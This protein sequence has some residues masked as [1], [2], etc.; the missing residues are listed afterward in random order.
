MLLQRHTPALRPMTTAHL[1]QTM[2]LLGLTA[3]ELRE[4]IEAELSTNPALELVEERRCPS[5]RRVLPGSSSCPL[6][7]QPRDLLSD[8]PIVFV[9]PRQDFY[10]YSKPAAEETVDD[11]YS[12]APVEQSLAFYV[13][14]QIAP[15][16]GPN[17]RP[18]AAHILTSLDED[19]LLTVPL[20]EIARYQHVM[21]SSVEKVLK[22]IQR[23]D[24]IGVGS[25][26]PREA[27]LVQLEVLA[28][29]RPVP[30]L[31]ALAIQKGMDL[32][33]HRRYQELGRLLGI[34]TIKARETAKFIAGNLNPFPGRSHWGEVGVT[35]ARSD[36]RQNTY[37]YPDVIISKLND[38]DESPLVVEVA[39]PLYGTLR[40]NPL[41]KEALQS[42]PPEKSEQW[43]SDI[44]KASLLIKCLQQRNHTLV[45]LMDYLA[46]LQRNFIIKGDAHLKP[47]TRASIA[48]VL[49]VHEST[50]SRAVSGK[51][52]QFPNGHIGPLAG[53][54]DRSLQIR[55]A[56]KQIIEQEASPLSDQELGNLLAKQGFSVAR[57]TVAKY[58]TMEG[59]LPAHL[60]ISSNRPVACSS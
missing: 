30:K 10:S 54:F 59:I 29:T 3:V 41:F 27:L 42:S 44:E 58:R 35:Q 60:R 1:A 5:C 9:S 36:T 17:E 33:S 22:Q 31:A 46:R 26:T 6:C 43:R 7:S 49:D 56:L 20:V 28:E 52:I 2:T 11:L 55:T 19:G 50:I 53:F 47:I 48:K 24:P 34:S 25:P 15:E 23:A 21:L 12:Q 13:M 8:Q 4:R 39:M 16:L 14:R 40:I 45:R 37:Y 57:R 18:I 38:R 51:S 32:L